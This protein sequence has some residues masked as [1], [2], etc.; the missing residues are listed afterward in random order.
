MLFK[1]FGKSQLVILT[2]Y[3]H[4]MGNSPSLIVV[5]YEGEPYDTRFVTLSGA[6]TGLSV[7]GMDTFSFSCHDF[8]LKDLEAARHRNELEKADRKYL[9]IDYKM[10][11]TE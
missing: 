10:R 3:S 6:E 8:T 1:Y 4:A 11:G 9:Y 2:E 5:E 7:I